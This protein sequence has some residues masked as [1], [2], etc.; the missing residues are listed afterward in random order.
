MTSD[1]DKAHL[2]R[3]VMQTRA[4]SQAGSRGA[5][6]HSMIRA[7]RQRTQSLDQGNEQQR[8]PAQNRTER[9]KLLYLLDGA[10]ND[11]LAHI[12]LLGEVEQLAD[13][14]RALGP[15]AAGD[16]HVGQTGQVL[17]KWVGERHGKVASGSARKKSR[18]EK[19]GCT[20]GQMER[21]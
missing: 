10:A 18:I 11:V 4:Y 17:Q 8:T 21:G 16:G 3:G 7:A 12:I 5:I 20:A 6:N 1:P 13:L 14:G 9:E 15:E 19:K 2:A